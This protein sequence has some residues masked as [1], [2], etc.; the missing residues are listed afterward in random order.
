MKKLLALVST[1]AVAVAVLAPSDK[2]A[3]PA[4]NAA[5]AQP[6][7]LFEASSYKETELTR[8]PNG[9]FYV[10]AYVNGAPISFIVDTGASSVALTE[11][12]ARAA[13]L[14][15]SKA[16]FEP[17]ART[18]SGIARGKLLTLPKVSIEGKEVMEVEAMIIEGAE[19]SLLGQSYLARITGV[20][21]N[22]DSMVLR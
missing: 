15:F 14:Q 1:F 12:D 5:P 19:Q 3:A 13:G 4:A 7:G 20:Q 9:H 16:E 8:K 10:T 17:V 21:M 22:G 18:A 11:D 6:A 2:P